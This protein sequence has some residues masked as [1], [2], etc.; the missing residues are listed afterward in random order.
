MKRLNGVITKTYMTMVK[1][2]V[3]QENDFYKDLF[4]IKKLLL[5]GQDEI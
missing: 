4:H 3:F 1:Y 5:G 2:I